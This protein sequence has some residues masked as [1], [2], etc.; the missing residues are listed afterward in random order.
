MDVAELHAVGL[1]PAQALVASEG[2][3]HHFPVRRQRLI[4]LVAD[5]DNSLRSAEFGG[6]L[7]DGTD[8]LTQGVVV[9]NR[10]HLHRHFGG[11]VGIAVSI[12]A[13][14]GAEVERPGVWGELYTEPSELVVELVEEIAD[15][16]P[17]HLVEVV[18]HRSG[19]VDGI[20]SLAPQLIGLPH[21][22]DDFCEAPLNAI[23]VGFGQ[24]RVGA[25]L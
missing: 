10:H 6:D 16:V 1:P 9:L 20:G 12:T 8:E 15:N 11:H 7:L 21:E 23:L 4:Q 17:K 19:L 22:V 5:A 18:D 3:R 2:R 14:P 24:P 25:L 13:H